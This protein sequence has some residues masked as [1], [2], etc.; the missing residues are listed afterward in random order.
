MRFFREE[1][2]FQTDSTQPEQPDSTNDNDNDVNREHEEAD[3][4][5]PISDEQQPES[6]A[7]QRRRDTSVRG[8][9]RQPDDNQ[10]AQLDK[11]PNKK[12]RLSAP[13]QQDE[14]TLADRMSENVRFHIKSTNMVHF[15]LRSAFLTF[16]AL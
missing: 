10:R 9:E 12:S 1:L 6:A 11:P 3:E 13:E 8:V 4:Q 2:S 5:Q 15:L 14:R 7:N 16:G